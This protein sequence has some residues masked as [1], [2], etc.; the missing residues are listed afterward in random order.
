MIVIAGFVLLALGIVCGALMLLIPLGVVEGTLGLALWVLFPLFSIG[1]YLMAASASGNTAVPILSRTSGAVMMLLALAAAIA[2][3]LHA[4]SIF[5]PV[6]DTLPLWY[7][8]AIGGF[9]GATG[10]ASRKPTAHAT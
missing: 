8:L 1:G 10:L 5:Q 9:L 7:V 3:V 6:G 2:L 4:A